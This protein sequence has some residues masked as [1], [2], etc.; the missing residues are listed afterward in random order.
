MTI[1]DDP[2]REAIG[3]APIWTGAEG[4]A[5][6]DPASAG[7]DAFDPAEGTIDDVRAYVEA[8]PDELE[9]VLAAEKAG[10]DRSTLVAWLDEQVQ[11]GA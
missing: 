10:K 5:A 11:A 1:F 4:A 7:G 6:A 3:L 9:D 2:N 8:H